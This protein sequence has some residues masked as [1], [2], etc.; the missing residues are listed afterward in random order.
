M[1]TGERKSEV[2]SQQSPFCWAAELRY[3]PI[4]D[5]WGMS[6]G[7]NN[8]L[9]VDDPYIIADRTNSG[10]PYFEGKSVG[11]SNFGRPGIVLRS[12]ASTGAGAG[13]A[14]TQAGQN[15]FREHLLTW[16]SHTSR[17]P[18][19]VSPRRCPETCGGPPFAAR[20]RQSIRDT[21]DGRPT[22]D[23]RRHRRKGH[24]PAKV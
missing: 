3:A 14:T 20:C 1:R 13:F 17:T 15:A 7:S 9:T 8:I 4:A 16:V 6:M 19:P 24:A 2:R 12:K 5:S 23:R 21:E 10:H 11:T 18:P 22:P